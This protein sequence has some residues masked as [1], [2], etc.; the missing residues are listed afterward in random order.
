M[1]QR[2]DHNILIHLLAVQLH[3]MAVFRHIQLPP[4]EVDIVHQR[5][6]A[7]ALINAV[8]PNRH[9]HIE[10]LRVLDDLARNINGHK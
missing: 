1:P 6:I 3:H 9:I 4:L 5:F 7:V 10:G 2:F 8:H